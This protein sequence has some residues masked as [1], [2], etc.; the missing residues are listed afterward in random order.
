MELNAMKKYS[1]R[2]W[3]AVMV[4][5][6]TYQVQAQ[7][8]VAKVEKLDFVG[9]D[10]HFS[11]DGCKLLFTSPNYVGLSIYDVNTK[12]IEEISTA[13]GAGF[14]P[15]I[16]DNTITYRDRKLR[17]NFM[18]DISTGEKMEVENAQRIST[19]G[20]SV[21]AADDLTS[22]IVT[23]ATG[24]SK[25]IQPLGH[26]DYLN[27]SLSPE[28]DKLLFRVSGLGSFITDLNGEILSK[29]GKVEFPLWVTNKEILFTKT[30]D[31]GY[32]YRSSDLFIADE[33]GQ[34]LL[35]LTYKLDAIAI[36]PQISN[37]KNYV[38]FNTPKGDVYLLHLEE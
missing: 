36:Y 2:A 6:L 29:L 37:D 7:R 23:D 13:R 31:D 25:V 19:S 35:E 17:K 26:A 15:V 30:V 22:I 20:I 11:D 14:N 33:S 4:L 32:Q 34:I 21:K 18:Y 27:I 5:V 3:L 12:A 28:E 24:E 38:V 9:H 1:T 8:C 16:S 10:V